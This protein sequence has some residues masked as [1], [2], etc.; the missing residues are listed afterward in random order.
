MQE[1]NNKFDVVVIGGGP[2]GMMAAIKA[3]QSGASV[4]LLEK[5]ET[6]GSKLL[7][8]GGGRCNI[9]NSTFN[10][11]E[12]A[13]Q[14]G[15]EGFF[16]LHALSVFGVEKTIAFFNK[17]GLKTKVEKDGKVYCAT[18]KANDALKVL[19]YLLRNN[20]V[21]VINNSKIKE[22]KAKANQ[23]S[24]VIL[25]NGKEVTAKNYILA[26]G[27]KSYPHTGSTG[28]GYAFAEK[29]GHKIEKLRPALVPI[30]IK[31]EWVKK[32]QGLSLADAKLDIYL[33][34]KKDFSIS[35]EI[36]FTHYGLSGPVILGISEEIG[37]LL[38]KGNVTIALDLNSNLTPEALDKIIQNYFT[39]NINKTL[40]NCLTEILPS[41]LIPIIIELSKTE[42]N[43]KVNGITKEERQRLVVTI[44][45]LEMTVEGLLGFDQAMVTT[46]GVSLKEID[47]KT[48]KSK[49]IKNLF[50]AGEVI[51]LH[52]P[53]GGYNLQACWSTGYLAGQS[54][55]I[56][57][58]T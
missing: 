23:I 47:A 1:N 9:T 43:K 16:L 36:M 52:G 49:I 45:K 22:I 48:M 37:N 35:G 46:G 42:A 51:N 50:F 24:K 29:L 30:K 11:K 28:D 41:K 31:N 39:Q 58:N 33:N 3:G 25:E 26:T 32:A 27:G 20:E 5:N 7:L 6:L 8:T 56:D 55:T 18:N 57:K 13:Q 19:I 34:H 15:K 12:L 14:Y 10:E 53:T 44:K 2:A 54:A 38:E 40:K 17:N 4:A 21:T